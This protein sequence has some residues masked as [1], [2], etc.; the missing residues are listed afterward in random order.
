MSPKNVARTNQNYCGKSPLG[1]LRGV[2]DAAA[3]VLGGQQPEEVNTE[4]ST[5]TEEPKQEK[6][7]G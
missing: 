2:A 5:P 7:D 4:E 6:S 3:K 1:D